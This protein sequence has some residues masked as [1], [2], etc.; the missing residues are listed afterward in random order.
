MNIPGESESLLHNL[1]LQPNYIVLYNTML[2]FTVLALYTT[3]L[4][5]F[6]HCT[7]SIQNKCYVMGFLTDPMWLGLFYFESLAE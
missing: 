7:V 3:T 5:C 6:G 2:S 4:N 1:A